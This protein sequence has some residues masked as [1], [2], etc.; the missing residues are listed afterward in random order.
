MADAKE[1]E[2][3]KMEVDNDAENLAEKMKR[4]TEE[5][6]QKENNQE[7]VGGEEE[8][9]ETEEQKAAKAEAAELEALNDDLIDGEGYEYV[10]NE[11]V[12]DMAGIADEE[13][14]GED[15]P[16]VVFRYSHGAQTRKAEEDPLMK[17]YGVTT[18]NYTEFSCQL[19]RRQTPFEINLDTLEEKPWRRQGA[20]LDDY[21]NFGF[22]EQTW[23]EYAE[24]AEQQTPGM[25]NASGV[26]LQ[27]QIQ[28]VTAPPT[29]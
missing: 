10:I 23:K 20:T 26:P 8:E 29:G 19:G 13:E 5:E 18:Q 2:D 17:Q 24:S 12:D 4:E 14:G 3:G 16:Q 28:H 15:Q 25:I 22:N 11:N 6:Q 1:Q 27:Q 21:F 9:T 7:A